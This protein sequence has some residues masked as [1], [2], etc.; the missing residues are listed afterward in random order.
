MGVRLL[1]R[2]QTT[3]GRFASSQSAFLASIA[4][5]SKG[6]PCAPDAACGLCRV[7]YCGLISL[8]WLAMGGEGRQ[9][10]SA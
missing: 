4:A 2:Y 3:R 6:R 1:A 7:E 9:G 10:K 8:V 5:E